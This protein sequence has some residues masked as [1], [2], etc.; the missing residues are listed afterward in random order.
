MV[1][2]TST[3]KDRWLQ[4]FLLVF[5][6]VVGIVLSDATNEANGDTTEVVEKEEANDASKETTDQEPVVQDPALGSLSGTITFS[7]KPIPP[8]IVQVTK[9]VETCK[10]AGDPIDE[11]TVSDD[12]HLA[13]VVI[14]VQGAKPPSGEWTWNEPKDGYVLRQEHCSFSPRVLVIKNGSNVQVYNDDNVAHN[15]NTGQWNVMQPKGADAIDKPI[16]SRRPLRVGCNIHSWMEAWVYPA[17][18][19]LYAISDKDGKFSIPNVPPGKYRAV[20]WHPALRQQRLR[21]TID[22]GKATTQDVSFK[23]PIK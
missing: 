6:L 18:T 4:T 7:G 2:S 8:R 14:E 12:G 15:V 23:S 3:K 22:A 20:A 1:Q 17:Q 10:K 9:D 16:K 5:S 13:G 19:P 21:V 11:I